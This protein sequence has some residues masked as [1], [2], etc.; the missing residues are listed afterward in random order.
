MAHN[1][2]M[3]MEKLEPLDLRKCKT[4]GDIVAGMEK[5]S[6]GARML[7]E[8]TRKIVKWTQED[9]APII[10]FDGRTDNAFGALL[11]YM[12]SKKGNKGWFSRIMRPEKYASH[13]HIGGRILVVGGY[14]ERYEEAIYHKPDEVIFINPFGMAKPDQIRDGYFPNVVFSDPRFVLPVIASVLHEKND[15]RYETASELIS[16]LKKCGGLAEE[17]HSGFKTLISMANDPDCAVIYTASGAMTIAQMNLICCDLIDSGFIQCMATTGALICHGLVENIG[18]PHYKYN[19]DFSDAVLATERL[20]RVTDTLEPEENLDQV[21]FL[22]E[23]VASSYIRPRPMGSFE[24]NQLIGSH[25]ATAFPNQRG[26]LKSAYEKEIPV[27]IPA[28]YDSEIGNDLVII[29]R[30]RNH[31][32]LSQIVIDQNRD[33]EKLVDFVSKKKRIGIFTVGGG[34]PRNYIQNVAPL[35]EIMNERLGL[36]MPD[37]KFSYGCRICPDPMWHGHLSGCT[38]NE[39]VS[40]RKFHPNALKSEIHEDATLVLPFLVKALMEHIS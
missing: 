30:K 2:R 16:D 15:G 12:D 18:L 19:P 11:H 39:G 26:I 14:S 17:I 25:L 20:N 10:I 28:F 4:V 22:I 6:F 29:N 34:T 27:F 32:L 3:K 7:G 5:C 31:N 9:P 13:N 24:F 8:V 38:Y 33:S 35:I 1:V 23:E 21:E 36:I 40:W 37:T